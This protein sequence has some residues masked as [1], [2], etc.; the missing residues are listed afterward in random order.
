MRQNRLWMRA[1]P[2]TNIVVREREAPLT[3]ISLLA[4]SI[5]AKSRY[6]APQAPGFDY[7]PSGRRIR[8]WENR[9]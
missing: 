1:I 7:S 2:L 6:K 3:A 9:R 8:D 5:D 4:R